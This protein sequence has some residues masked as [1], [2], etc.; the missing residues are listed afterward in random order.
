MKWHPWKKMRQ[1]CQRNTSFPCEICQDDLLLEISKPKALLID[2]FVSLFIFKYSTY[3]TDMVLQPKSWTLQVTVKNFVKLPWNQHVD[4]SARKFNCFFFKK[5][6]RNKIR[7]LEYK[8]IGKWNCLFLIFKNNRC[9]YGSQ[10]L[11]IQDA[12]PQINSPNN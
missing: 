7:K 2:I 1:I 3:W 4:G 5:N 12:I 6:L 11:V 10:L 8:N 9:I